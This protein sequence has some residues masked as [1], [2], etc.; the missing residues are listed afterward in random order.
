[1]L[2]HPRESKKMMLNSSLKTSCKDM[3]RTCCAY[4]ATLSNCLTKMSTTTSTSEESYILCCYLESSCFHEKSSASLSKQNRLIQ[5]SVT[6]L[7]LASS[8]RSTLWGT[9][10]IM[11]LNW[12][13]QSYSR[14]WRKLR[15]SG[16]SSRSRD[17]KYSSISLCSHTTQ[18]SA[19]RTLTIMLEH[20]TSS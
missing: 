4:R 7:T 20:S 5:A 8:W 19:K 12:K 11:E 2:L 6:D 15:E 14:A 10:L 3:W 16:D 1:M 17:R 18:T 9:T 13:M